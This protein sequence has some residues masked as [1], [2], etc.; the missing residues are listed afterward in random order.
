MS[1]G[2]PASELPSLDQEEILRYSRHLIIPDVGVE[3]QRRLKAARV[4]MVGAGGLG[5]PIGLYLAAAGVGTLGLVEFDV[6]DVTN[7]QRQ[8]IHGTKDVGR[9]KVES[10][11]DRIHDVNPHVKVVPY[12]T[13]LT[14]ANALDIVKD[15]DL[16]VDGTDNF[17]TRYL[18]NDACVLLGKPN[19]YGSIFR[20]EGQSTVFCTT[21]GPC[22]RCL[23]PEPP[24]PG[25]VP[26]CAEGGVLG[27]LPG[28][29][30]LVQATEA[31][32][33]I[34]GAGE[35][36]VGR[37]LLV[38]ALRMSFRTVKLRKNPACPACGTHELKGLVDYV[39]FCGLRGQEDVTDGIPTITP[40]ELDERRRRKDAF[41]LI[42]VREPHE[43]EIGRIEGARLAP[44][45]SFA[46]T[47]RTLDSARDVVVY[48]KSGVRSAKAVRQLQAAGFKRVWNLAGGILRWS[49]EIDP[50][51]PRY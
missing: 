11:R 41:D 15:Y 42:D 10:A 35:P 5:S 45:S 22:Y 48:C 31:V 30:G 47:L 19:V 34:V 6:V 38:D 50:T 24:P 36:L 37:L 4:L 51:V 28:L 27:V 3:G 23:Y 20:F 46:E 18:V 17:A 12:D 39:Q 33:L 2:R 13:Q 8:V 43:W 7:L 26:S 29:L 14:S 16:V 49:E 21:D 32:K 9:K 25:L 44:L 1:I 40:A